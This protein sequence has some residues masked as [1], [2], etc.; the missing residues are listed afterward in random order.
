[1]R[2]CA[3]D[4]EYE[5]LRQHWDTVNRPKH[6]HLQWGEKQAEVLALV[7]ERT[8][9]E[10]EEVKRTSRRWLYISGS[11]GSGKSAV[12]LEAALRAARQALRVLIVCPTG[13]L[14][15]SLKAQLPEL[16]GIE[17]IQ[18]DTIHGV[19]QYKRPHVLQHVRSCV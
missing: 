13:Q 14:V 5:L 9:Y 16:D 6:R 19:L 7:T 3:D 12:L 15:H 4:A 8:S 1:M 10:D 18:I 17:N 11:P 2:N